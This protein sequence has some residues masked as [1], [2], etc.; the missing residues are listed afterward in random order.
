MSSIAFS[1]A[2]LQIELGQTHKAIASLENAKVSANK[3]E[4]K[5]LK[6]E[7]DELLNKISRA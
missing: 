5:E 2:R 4:D 1:M 7:I 6:I 3:I